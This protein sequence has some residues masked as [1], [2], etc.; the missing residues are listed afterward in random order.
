MALHADQ[1]AI[2]QCSISAPDQQGQ[3]FTTEGFLIP[4]MVPL[5]D[6]GSLLAAYD[7]ANQYSPNAEDSRKIARVVMDALKAAVEEP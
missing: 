6:I 5:A 2:V 3:E 4:L 1:T 7:A